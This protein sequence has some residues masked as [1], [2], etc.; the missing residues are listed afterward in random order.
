[1][2]FVEAVETR[3]SFDKKTESKIALANFF[4]RDFSERYAFY[5][6]VEYFKNLYCS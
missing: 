1:M 3:S 6:A 2:S 4:E 5:Y